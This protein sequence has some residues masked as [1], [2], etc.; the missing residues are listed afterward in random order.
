MT[1]APVLENVVENNTQT[2]QPTPEQI[3]L[4]EFER[5]AF[6]GPREEQPQAEV[7]PEVPVVP[8]QEEKQ[9]IPDAPPAFNPDTYFKDNFGWDNAEVAKQEIEGLRNK[10]QEEIWKSDEAKRIAALINEGKEEEL[11]N[12]FSSRKMMKGLDSMDTDQKLKLYYKMQNPLYDDEII[13]LK[14]KKE[15]G[16]DD[17]PYKDVDGNITDHAGYR[18]AKADSAYKKQNDLEKAQAFFNQYKTK[19]ELPEIQL[20]TQE[21]DKDYEAYKASN[22]SAEESYNKVVAP[23]IKSLKEADV[24]L[25]VSI[26]DAGNKMQFDISIVPEASDFEAARQDSLS[27]DLLKTCYDKNGNFLPKNLQRLSL[28][29]NNFEKYAQSIARQAVN[30]ERKRVIEEETKGGGIQR[31]FNTNHVEPTELQRLEKMAFG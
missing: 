19:L 25:T 31:D 30:A 13:D 17:E 26:N 16:F 24:P 22:A 3:Q 1:D 12:I 11:A 21:V 15:Y 27:L 8:L 10:K 9:I 29:A 7:K 4:K 28:L 14:L 2:N 6:G 5:M 20:P 18:L 23:A